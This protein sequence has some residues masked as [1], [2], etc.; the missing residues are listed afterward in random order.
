MTDEARVAMRPLAMLHARELLAQCDDA[1]KVCIESGL[2]RE[3]ILDI[4][5]QCG[6][7]NLL[8]W[9]DCD[10]RWK[11]QTEFRAAKSAIEARAAKAAIES[12]AATAGEE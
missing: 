12:A 7:E 5:M 6:I 3:M 10:G 8:F 1:A 9:K 2:L 4:G 11:V